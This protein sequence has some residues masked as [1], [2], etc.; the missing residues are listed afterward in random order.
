MQYKDGKNYTE[1]IREIVIDSGKDRCDIE[2]ECKNAKKV[3]KKILTSLDMKNVLYDKK[4]QR[5]NK[6][7]FPVHFFMH[8]EPCKN[9][10]IDRIGTKQHRRYICAGVL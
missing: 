7:F 8:N 9:S 1:F 5:N 3:L 10:Y 4:Y 2:D 6:K